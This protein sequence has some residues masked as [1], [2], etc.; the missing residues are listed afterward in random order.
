MGAAAPTTGVPRM[1]VV[2]AGAIGGITAAL[3]QARGYP[4]AVLG[5][6]RPQTSQL[7]SPGLQVERHGETRRY[8]LDAHRTVQQL[9]GRFD[10]CLLAVKAAALDDVLGQL[11]L[12]G[13][14]DT[15][16][17]LGNGLVQEQVAAVVGDDKLIAASV[18]WGATNLGDGHVRQTSD[19]LTT[20]GELDGSIRP[21]TETLAT[22]LSAVGEVRVTT[23]IRG[24]LWSKLLLN[25]ALSGISVLGGC[26]C[27]EALRAPH[28]PRALKLVWR[29]GYELA[30]RQGIE[31]EP[32]LGLDPGDLASPSRPTFDRALERV[33]AQSGPTRA[34]MLQD[35]ERGLLTEVDVING[36]VARAAAAFS[37]EAP[38]NSRV[39]ELV[40]SFERGD[41]Q[42]SVETFAEFISA[43]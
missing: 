17:T 41:R 8:A 10:F 4:V 36:A 14:I 19:N 18:E 9:D 7:R 31:L 1:L 26:S 34:S 25:S 28:G 13:E 21:R 11:A 20:L 38:Y 43:A 37:A 35:L 30:L 33:I 42:P 32:I 2:G 23:N 22:A 29:E 15:Y 24:K 39:V 3:M 5:R 12:R 40:H 6:D 16:V 27:E